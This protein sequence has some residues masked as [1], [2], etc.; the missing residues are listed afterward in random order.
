[1]KTESEQMEQRIPLKEQQLQQLEYSNM[2]LQEE[3]RELTADLENKQMTLDELNARLEKYKRTNARLVAE[4][5]SQRRKKIY[6]DQRIR[7]SQRKINTVR[8]SKGLPDRE[9]QKQVKELKNEIREYL[10]MGI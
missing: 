1:M 9:K 2:M 7:E 5:E 4:N 6:L 10:R 3:T 8:N